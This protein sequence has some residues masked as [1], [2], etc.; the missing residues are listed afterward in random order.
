MKE[1]L[2]N[3]LV[4][5]PLARE[6][7]NKDRAIVNLLMD[8]YPELK[9]IDKNILIEFIR[10]NNHVDRLWR[11]ILVEHEELRGSDYEEKAI[12]VKK[13][14]RELGYIT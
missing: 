10:A 2:F 12:L 5:Q 3:Y 14:Q 8:E 1:K 7:K 13:K 9:V 4:I 11:D 6:R